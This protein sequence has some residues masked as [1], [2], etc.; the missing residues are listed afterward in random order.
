MKRNVHTIVPESDFELLEGQDALTLYQFNTKT[1]RHYFC[2]CVLAP[3][4]ELS[5]PLKKECSHS[6]L[7]CRICGICSF[8]VPRSNPDGYAVTVSCLDPG[9]VRLV[10][11]VYHDGQDW[12]KN[13]GTNLDH[14]SK[15]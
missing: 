3:A 6:Q 10:T 2:K 4:L 14:L 8:Y 15:H 11:T 9:T 1:A 13:I 5:P 7:R 12:E